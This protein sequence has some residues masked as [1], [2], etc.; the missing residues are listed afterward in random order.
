M[1][2]VPH[3]SQLSDLVEVDDPERSGEAAPLAFLR[4]GRAE[5]TLLT[6]LSSALKV[7]RLHALDNQAAR[8]AMEELQAALTAFLSTQGLAL[9]I[10]GEAQRVYVNGRLMRG[11]GRAGGGWLEDVAGALERQGA[12]GLLLAG[13]WDL[14]ATRELMGA[15]AAPVPAEGPKVAGLKQ[16]L[17]RVSAPATVQALDAAEA[18]ALAHEE[19]EGYLSES[20]RA[21]FYFARLVTLAEV[22]LQAVRAGRAPDV[23]ARHV[24]QTFMKVIDSLAQPLFEAR[25][26]GCGVLD[27]ERVDP[28]A[29]HGAR[30]AVVALVMGRLL[31]LTRG[32]LADLGQAALLH[33]LGR[34]DHLRRPNPTGEAEDPGGLEAHLLRGV[35]F[36]L[37]GRNYAASGLL[38]LV[39]ALEHHR[40]ADEVPAQAVLRAPHVLTQVIAVADAFDRLEHG[41]P[42]RPPISPAEALRTLAGEPHR[43]D[44][45][46]VELLADAIGHTP[47]GTVIRLRSGEVAVVV[48]GGARQGHRPV[49]RRLLLANGAPD[50]GLAMAPLASPDD[51]ADELPPDVGVDWR[52]AVLS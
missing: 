9:V 52:R 28:L 36:A 44:P 16:A 34:V 11:G 27:P 6:R 7:A 45:A 5:A 8:A 37:R 13:E 32:H 14:N 48:A 43:Y 29:A 40:T 19:E 23:H 21:A 47:R 41:L 2:I 26:L 33:D 12:T 15:F 18:A 22:G 3:D 20:Q 17:T 46:V 24:R 30:V 42:W 25:L 38:R 4:A 10:V 35:R 39:V 49:I 50:P 1:T 31:G 51:V